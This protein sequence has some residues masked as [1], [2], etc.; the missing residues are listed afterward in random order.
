M[1][2]YKGGTQI[3]FGKNE[4][5]LIKLIKNYFKR[6]F[7]IKKTKKYILKQNDYKI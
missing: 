4:V 5:Y 7:L 6:V 3:K 2:K 1:L